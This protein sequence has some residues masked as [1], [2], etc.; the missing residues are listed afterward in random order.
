MERKATTKVYSHPEKKLKVHLHPAKT[1][2]PTIHTQPKLK[3]RPFTPN[4]N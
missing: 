3:V 2:G 1:K 4:Q